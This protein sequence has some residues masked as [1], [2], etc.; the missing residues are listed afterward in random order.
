[1]SQITDLTGTKWEFNETITYDGPLVMFTILFDSDGK[2][3]NG[4]T[5][6]PDDPFVNGIFYSRTGGDTE[7][8]NEANGWAKQSYRTIEITGGT[9]A[10]NADLIDW[11]QSNATQIIEPE[12]DPKIS[13]GTLPLV[14][15]SVGNAEMQ[16]I[17]V[18]NV[19]VWEKEESGI[20]TL[21]ETDWTTI[22]QISDKH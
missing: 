5:I 4:L 12:E 2:S 19:K 21:E 14:S 16:S 6:D 7:V 20:G 13:I 11:L 15:A 8:Y 18:G 10:T 9:D 17:W 1:M 22:K 3:F